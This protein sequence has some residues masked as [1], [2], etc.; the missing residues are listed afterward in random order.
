M[1]GVLQFFLALGRGVMAHA[2]SPLTD[3]EEVLGLHIFYVH[4]T[5]EVHVAF[6]PDLFR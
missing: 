6:C 3:R 1:Y 2:A 5:Y 4:T